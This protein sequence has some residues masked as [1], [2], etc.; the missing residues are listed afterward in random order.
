MNPW[1]YL[2]EEL[3]GGIPV[4]SDLDLNSDPVVSTDLIVGWAGG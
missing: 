2:L 1:S 3:E 4:T